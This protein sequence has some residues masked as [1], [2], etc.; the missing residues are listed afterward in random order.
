M[1]VY[2]TNSIGVIQPTRS[3]TEADRF[4]WLSQD[5]KAAHVA[6]DEALAKQLTW[7]VGYAEADLAIHVAQRLEELAWV[8]MKAETDRLHLVRAS[9]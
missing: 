8:A 2:K 7:G 4:I 6:L 3:S 1:Q 9:E 5:W